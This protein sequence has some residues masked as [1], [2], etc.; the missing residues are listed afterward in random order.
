MVAVILG[1]FL[2]SHTETGLVSCPSV[3]MMSSGVLRST[4]CKG[5]SKQHHTSLGYV[6]AVIVMTNTN[7]YKK[8]ATE[9][10]TGFKQSVLERHD[11]NII[12]CPVEI[13]ELSKTIVASE[14]SFNL[15]IVVLVQCLTDKQQ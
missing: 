10:N 8:L 4:R 3:L 11:V 2:W 1:S 9:L 5:L 14:K 15:S 7:T 6:N 12:K 13:I